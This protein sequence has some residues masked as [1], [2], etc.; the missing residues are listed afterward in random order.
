M[1]W[2]NLVGLGM[3][4]LGIYLDAWVYL[5]VW[6]RFNIMLAVVFAMYIVVALGLS[7]WGGP[8]GK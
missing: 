1:R 6:E 8:S 7:L 2:F 3:L 4:T 5:Y